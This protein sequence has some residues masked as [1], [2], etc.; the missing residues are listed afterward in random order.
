MRGFKE[1]DRLTIV[2]TTS[3][4]IVLLLYAV[5]LMT[6][7]HFALGAQST[8]TSQRYRVKGSATGRVFATAPGNPLILEE[9]NRILLTL[10]HDKI[11]HI[12]VSLSYDGP[13]GTRLRPPHSSMQGQLLSDTGGN[14]YI[15]ITP[16]RL[17]R[18]QVYITV[19]F[20]DGL[21]DNAH[22]DADVVLPERRPDKLFIT[23]I[24]S[25]NFPVVYVPLALSVPTSSYDNLFPK[26]LYHGDPNPVPIP[27]K[28][29]KFRLIYG[30]DNGPSISLDAATGQIKAI[31]LGHTM[32]VTT[33]QGLSVLTCV[34]V[35]RRPGDPTDLTL[36][37]E[38]VPPGM[39]PLTFPWK[40]S[41]PPPRV[42]QPRPQD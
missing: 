30:T 16:R 41:A 8:S 15:N 19:F 42:T 10:S 18:L 9:P 27:A 36:C 35:I 11:H 13:N 32:V 3:D 28:D 26:A 25:P 23:G 17:G 38:L 31:H 37:R 40:G 21:V 6:Y 20:D 2:K 1:A 33:F 14:E 4:R 34:N 5:C 22:F 29:V 24:G 39:K 12:W 7:A